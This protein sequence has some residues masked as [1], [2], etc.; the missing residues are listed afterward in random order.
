[1]HFDESQKTFRTNMLSPSS[2]SKNKPNKNLKYSNYQEH[3]F[4]W[5]VFFFATGRFK[6]HGAPKRDIANRSA[7][8]TA[9]GPVGNYC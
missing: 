9:F 1:V 7:D 6:R 4:Y 3:A 5:F 8:Y 2:R